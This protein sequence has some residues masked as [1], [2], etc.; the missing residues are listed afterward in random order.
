MPR[1]IL[2]V[3]L[4]LIQRQ[5]SVVRL[6]QVGRCF[7]QQTTPPPAAAEADANTTP[8]D[9]HSKGK[10][11]SDS[12]A[13]A[14]VQNNLTRL[15]SLL[16]ESSGLTA[17]TVLKQQVQDASDRFDQ[18]TTAMAAARQ[19]VKVA[20]SSHEQAHKKHVSLLMRRDEWS[21]DDAQSF[22]NMT[23]LEVNTRQ[24]LLDA[25][26]ALQ[27]SEAEAL[28]CQHAYMDVMRRRYHEEQLWQ[29]KW[30][31][32]GTYGTWSLIG[33]NT[34]V[35]VVGQYFMEARE[36]KRMNHMEE[37]LRSFGQRNDTLP[38]SSS[39]TAHDA[40]TTSRTGTEDGADSFGDP[41][42]SAAVAVSNSPSSETETTQGNLQT[43][44]AEEERDAGSDNPAG[45]DES[46]QEQGIQPRSTAL[47]QQ[48]DAARNKLSHYLE[49]TKQHLHTPSMALGA[50]V[51]A[52]C[53]VA[54]SLLA[55]TKR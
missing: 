53:V 49:E 46:Q 27:R 24:A 36:R 40:S 14:V 42:A 34:I 8:P 25:Q 3:L 26:S 52:S 47:L 1:S 9:K 7:S 32:L 54:L 20:Q 16:E 10:D 19:Q 11:D 2:H 22:V 55:N 15:Q 48:L 41:S 38:H 33:I 21:A 44:N 28:Q 12:D 51:G 35:F 37:T 23:A 29:D 50:V 4:P 6:V 17:L 18:A 30:R 13:L 43:K 31:L 45:S 39:T 5:A